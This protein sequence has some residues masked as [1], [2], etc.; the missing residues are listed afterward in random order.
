MIRSHVL[1]TV[2]YHH[3]FEASPR[4]CSY[5]LRTVAQR[6]GSGGSDHPIKIG[7][8]AHG[9]RWK[10]QRKLKTG[11]RM[12][13]FKTASSRVKKTMLVLTL[14]HSTRGG[15]KGAVLTIC[16]HLQMFNWLP[17]VSGERCIPHAQQRPVCIESPGSVAGD[18]SSP[19]LSTQVG[20]QKS[21]ENKGISR[22]TSKGRERKAEVGPNPT[23]YPHPKQRRNPRLDIH[24]NHRG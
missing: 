5:F 4:T 12:R 21:L 14:S 8:A 23:S 17:C 6:A 2:R 7:P 15:Q 9:D 10:R 1:P 22:Q 20:Q 24:R 16:N 19:H 13:S 3:Q 11:Q 18:V